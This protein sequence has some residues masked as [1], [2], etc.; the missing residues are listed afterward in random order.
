[1]EQI[2]PK[3]DQMTLAECNNSD[4]FDSL[5]AAQIPM[6]STQDPFWVNAVRIILSKAAFEMRRDKDRSVMKLFQTLL[7]ADFDFIQQYLKGTGSETLASDKKTVV[8][9]RSVLVTMAS[10]S[11]LT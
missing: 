11:S 4:N 9:T 5:A 3:K 7:T 1:M 10:P 8:S 2:T 6:R